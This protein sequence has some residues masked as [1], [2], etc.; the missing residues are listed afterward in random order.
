MI[1]K[2]H[3][4]TFAIPPEDV[5]M[6]TG[7]TIHTMNGL[8]MKVRTVDE[9]EPLRKTEG[10]WTKQHLKRGLSASGQPYNSEDDIETQNMKLNMELSIPVDI[11]PK[12]STTLEG[13]E[14]P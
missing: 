1:M 3:D 13:E 11:K 9:N 12:D 10:Y 6:K 14:T 5:G 2:N 7:A 4:F 8:Q